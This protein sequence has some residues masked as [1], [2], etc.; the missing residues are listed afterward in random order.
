MCLEGHSV[1]S[2]AY[3]QMFSFNLFYEYS[4]MV[5]KI[6]IPQFNDFLPESVYLASLDVC[7]RSPTVSQTSFY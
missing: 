5:S 3:R 1:F 6:Y 4:Y 2:F 7:S